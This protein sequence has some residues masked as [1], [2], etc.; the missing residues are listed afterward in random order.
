MPQIPPEYRNIPNSRDQYESIDLVKEFYDQ[1]IDH[2]SLRKAMGI[3]KEALPNPSALSLEPYTGVF[4]FEQKKHLLNRILVG[5]SKRHLLDLDNMT[6]DQAIDLIFEPDTLNE[7]TNIYYWEMNSAQYKERYESDDVAPNEPFISRPYK[8]L[9]PTFEEQFGWERQTA[10]RSIVYDGMYNQ[11]TSI[12]WKLFIFLHNLVPTR[13]FDTLGHKG[14]YNYLKLIFDSCFG[15]YKDFIYN[16]TLDASMLVYLNLA[17]SQKETPDEN[18]AREVQELFT[19]GKRPFAKFS[20]GDV[21]EIARALV[22]WSYDYEGIVYGEGHENLPHFNQWNH[23]TGDKVFSEFYGNK[24]IK[25]KEG[26]AGAEE[27]QEVIDILFDTEENGI[28]MARRLYQFFIYPELNEDVEEKIIKPLAQ[29]YRD[30]NYSISI[31]L[32]TLLKSRHFFE[33]GFENTLIKPPLEFYIGCLKEADIFNGSLIHWDGQTS[34]HSV[35]EPEYF[36]DRVRD[37]SYLK[38]QITQTTNWFSNN[39]GMELFY[40]PS[41][42]GWPAYYQEPVYDLFWINSSTIARRADIVRAVFD[43]GMWLNEM[44]GNHSVN[45]K[46]NFINY[47][48]SY[49]N[50]TDLESFL[51]EAIERMLGS[52]IPDIARSRIRRILID[53]FDTSH[54]TSL[55]NGV[56]QNEPNRNDYDTITWRLGQALASIATL[57][58]FQMH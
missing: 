41:V 24:V 6:L 5:Y 13:C 27:L 54:W 40:P 19:V 4:G 46:A 30:N 31:A 38:Y 34:H 57:G 32:K 15:N 22:G 1:N 37:Q 53:Q 26:D 3:R 55:V 17:L 56:L 18:Y 47:I 33:G 36:S 11:K 28:Y 29:I 48:K 16:V 10:I 7:P 21:R 12:H 14:A 43:W 58:E 52:T 42:S 45:L 2:K 51:D 50:P 8:R 9:N 25:G 35:F 39:L 20:E 49:D 23:D 44:V